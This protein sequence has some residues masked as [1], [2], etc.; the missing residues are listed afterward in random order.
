MKNK[1]VKFESYT[2]REWLEYEYSDEDIIGYEI[3]DGHFEKKYINRMSQDSNSVN[4]KLAYQGFNKTAETDYVLMIAE[5]IKYQGEKIAKK[6]CL[7]HQIA[8]CLYKIKKEPESINNQYTKLVNYTLGGQFY[9]FILSEK[10]P[11]RKSIDFYSALFYAS[12]VCGDIKLAAML[13]NK[14]ITHVSSF[15][16][17]NICVGSLVI[18][19]IICLFYLKA[20]LKNIDELL[21]MNERLIETAKDLKERPME[22]ILWL[23]RSRLLRINCKK[24]KAETALDI[25]HKLIRNKASWKQ[26]TYYCMQLAILNGEKEDLIFKLFGNKNNHIEVIESV[27]GWRIGQM[28]ANNNKYAHIKVKI[29]IET[30]IGLQRNGELKQIYNRI[31]HR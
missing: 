8:K 16:D 13:Y 3:L 28:V 11:R 23:N 29:P 31:L 25:S 19:N 10:F 22:A 6:D 27:M 14:Y 7:Y 1:M 9:H 2:L 12:V 30:K 17:Q 20:K 18:K 4:E 5:M 15:Y 26:N 21:L 24:E